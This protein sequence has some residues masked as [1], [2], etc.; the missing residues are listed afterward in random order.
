MLISEV[1]KARPWPSNQEI[2]S[3][4]RSACCRFNLH[5]VLEEKYGTL[6]E[7]LYLKAARLCSEEN[8]KVEWHMEGFVCSK[9][10]RAQE[11][12]KPSIVLTPLPDVQFHSLPAE[13]DDLEM[14]SEEIGDGDRWEKAESHLVLTSP[15]FEGT[16]YRK[17]LDFCYITERLLDPSL[18]LDTKS[19]Q[20]GCTCTQLRCSPESCD[21]VY[22]FDN[23]N[24]DAEDIYGQRMH[25]R[26][27]YDNKGQII[28]EEGYLVYECNSMCS[29]NKECPN[30]VLQKG[31]QVKIEVYKTKQKGWAVRA[32]Q[33]ISRGTFIC[34]YLGEV[35]ND[36]EANKRGERYDNEG[37]SYLYDIDAHIDMS[38]LG[39]G[40]QP[41]VIDATKYGNV[42][43]FINHSCS[44]NLVNYQVLVESMDCQLAHIG[45][46]A[47]RD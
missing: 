45:L 31:V 36:Q 33:A 23:D 4:A 15:H 47:S 2:L 9:Q 16:H 30:R 24:D 6:P 11:N 32:V 5:A 7:R 39:V 34:E 3:I 1:Q 41:Y 44:P 40:V 13:L 14:T 18:G 38:D 8:I 27:P 20:L 35:L 42:A 43:R 26:F 10:C 25:G 46:Y 37:C 17:M 29:C 12:S 19:S 21:H 22:L 28:L